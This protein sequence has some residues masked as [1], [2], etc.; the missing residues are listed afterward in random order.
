MKETNASAACGSA[1][2]LYILKPI[3]NHLY[4]RRHGIQ[5]VSR[6]TTCSLV[7]WVS[8]FLEEATYPVEALWYT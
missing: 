5:G 6:K 8:S 7:T 4:N 3:A 2:Y 1:G